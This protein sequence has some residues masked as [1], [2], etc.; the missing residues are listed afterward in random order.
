MLNRD[1]LTLKVLLLLSVVLGVLASITD[2]TLYGLDPV[3]GAVLLNYIKLASVIVAAVTGWLQTSPL[4]GE[5]DDK[6]V[7]GGMRSIV[8]PFLLV[9]ALASGACLP[10][11]PP[12]IVTPAPTTEQVQAVRDQAE[13]LAKAVKEA[14]AAAVHIGRL[15][16]QA[17]AAGLIPPAKMQ[18]IAQARI[19]AGD[20]GLAFVEF[21]RTVTTEPSLRATVKALLS[22]FD[23]YIDAL[24]D[25]NQGGETIHVALAALRAYLGGE[26]AQ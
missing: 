13:V 8:L 1:S 7:G 22:V 14:S 5:N 10:K 16:D 6:R 4:P 3:F 20:K 19:N 2:P 21:A 15:A 12:A 17:Y 24:A 18:R 25:G 11:A 9:S 26:V 23:D